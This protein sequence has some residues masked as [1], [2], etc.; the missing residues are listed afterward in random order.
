MLDL[1]DE[2]FDGLSADDRLVVKSA[3]E[4]I[5][6][7]TWQREGDRCVASAYGGSVAVYRAPN[8][9]VVAE[10]S[11]NEPDADVR[12]IGRG[13]D[14]E[15]ALA[16]IKE[17]F[18]Y[19]IIG[20]IDAETHVGR[21]S[22]QLGT[23]EAI[24]AAE[25]AKSSSSPQGSECRDEFDSDLEDE[26]LRNY[27]LVTPEWFEELRSGRAFDFESEEDP[28]LRFFG[29]EDYPYDDE[30]EPEPDEEED[31]EPEGDVTPT[32]GDATATA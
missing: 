17:H 20:I 14:A 31:R 9:A 32:A 5:P 18:W 28:D 23:P 19:Y 15:R 11:I 3:A 7:A 29:I 12:I 6:Y 2:I 22:V 10:L 30:S 13:L 21:F 24:A 8:R 27:P 1:N 4:C 26:Y 25:A 16:R